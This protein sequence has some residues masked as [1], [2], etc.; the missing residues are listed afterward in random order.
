[1][2]RL[3]FKEVQKFTQIWLWV[4]LSAMVGLF[5]F[6]I[7]KQI[8]F[9]QPVGDHPT[10]DL[11]LLLTSLIPLATIG[12]FFSLRLITEVRK[13]GIFYRFAP[14]QRK[15]KLIPWADI[16]KCYVR[17]YKPISEYGGWGMRMGS[18]K[19]GKAFNVRG[20][21]GLQI[22]FKN[23]K[24]FLIGTQNPQELEGALNK[25][26]NETERYQF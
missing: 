2:S 3:Y 4:L 6:F 10:T 13:E 11:G 21:M 18:L 14:F 25:I 19:H 26:K 17:K 8:V 23:G 16:E 7:I 1:M 5:L 12:L 22:E 24:R 15:L 20:N 9:D